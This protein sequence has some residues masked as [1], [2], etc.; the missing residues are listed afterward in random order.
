MASTTCGTPGYVAPEV[1][2]KK[3][4]DHRC[5]IWA[6]GVVLFIMLSG[7]PPFYHPDNFELFELI[8]TGEYTFD[9]PAWAQ[10]S[11]EGKDLICRLL[12]VD[13]NQRITAEEL[14]AHKWITGD[15]KITENQVNVLQ[16]LRD[17][18]SKRRLETL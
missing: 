1:L 9:A 13:P 15:F 2:F 18:N 7:T 8:K 6:L 14:R 3:P 12:T 16:K 5:D 10:V 4:Y 11:Q 17:W